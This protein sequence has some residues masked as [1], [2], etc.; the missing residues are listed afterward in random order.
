MI[1]AKTRNHV[2]SVNHVLMF[3]AVLGVGALSVSRVQAA[4][5]HVLLRA[6]QLGGA[7]TY[8]VVS[9]QAYPA[10]LKESRLLDQAVKQAYKDVRSDWVEERQK[11]KKAA[12]QKNRDATRSNR[13]YSETTRRRD[14]RDSIHV[15]SFPLQQPESMV[16]RSLGSF[17]TPAHAESRKAYMQRRDA[18]GSKSLSS[19]NA[20]PSRLARPVKNFSSSRDSDRDLKTLEKEVADRVKALLAEMQSGVGDSTASK[21]SG[22]RLARPNEKDADAKRLGSGGPSLGS[23]I[24]RSLGKEK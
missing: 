15:G 24:G 9:K 3:A 19:G 1:N 6:P 10:R 7:A 17:P 11:K 14:S 21:L 12:I 23:G 13:N 16:I 22:S 4:G 20:L 2:A 8:E 5:N 18:M